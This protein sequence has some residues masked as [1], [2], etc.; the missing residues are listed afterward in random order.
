MRPLLFCCVA[1]QVS[2]RGPLVTAALVG[3]SKFVEPV[4]LKNL[5]AMFTILTSLIS[6]E[7]A[8]IEVG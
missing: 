1:M 7:A 8:P 4:F 3:L 5:P 2:A 6:C